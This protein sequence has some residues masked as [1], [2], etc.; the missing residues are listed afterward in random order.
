MKMPE[1][2]EAYITI[3]NIYEEMRDYERSMVFGIM[4]AYILKTDVDRWAHCA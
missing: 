4:G 1:L 3:S 2:S